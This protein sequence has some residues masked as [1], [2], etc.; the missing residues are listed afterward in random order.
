MVPVYEKYYRNHEFTYPWK[1]IENR[2]IDYI[3]YAEV[4]GKEVCY[5]DDFDTPVKY[6]RDQRTNE[7]IVYPNKYT[8][9][10]D[11][12]VTL[13]EGAGALKGISPNT[14]LRQLYFVDSEKFYETAAPRKSLFINRA[15]VVGS[16]AYYGNDAI[17]TNEKD[18]D[19]P[20]IARVQ[21]AFIRVD[22]YFYTSIF[23]QYQ[24]PSGFDGDVL[25]S[26]DKFVGRS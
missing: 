20:A 24:L 6:S 22:T 25:I 9:P 21:K 16:K 3:D 18:L 17:P 7:S 1:Q 8:L 26:I 5:V 19:N 10:D 13:D 4:A 14:L 23:N 11:Q 12:P 2:E 15:T